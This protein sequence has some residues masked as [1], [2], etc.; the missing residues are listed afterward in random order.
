MA[1]P[2]LV[3]APK[4]LVYVNSK[5]FGRC[6]SFSWTSQTPRKRIQT[7]D[8]M[9]PME[10]AATTTNVSWTMGV[11]R[12]IGDGGLQGAGVVSQQSELSREM[13]F[14]IQLVE[15][16]SGLTL[17]RSDMN[18][19]DSE[20]W[21]VTAKDLLLGNVSGSGISWVNETAS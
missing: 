3:S 16:T 13:Y 21:S 1:R 10:L 6:T 11:L 18:N 17:F 14:T 8:V 9:H 2:K 4:I 15:R 19:T 20:Q 7:I 12:T 5:L